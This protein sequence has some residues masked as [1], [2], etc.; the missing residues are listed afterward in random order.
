METKSAVSD[1]STQLADARPKI[2]QPLRIQIPLSINAPSR[3]ECVSKDLQ[4]QQS[5]FSPAAF[6]NT[7][8]FIIPYL[9]QSKTTKLSSLPTLSDSSINMDHDAQIKTAIRDYSTLAFSSKRAGKKDVEAAAYVSLG[10]IYD[11]Q[12]NYMMGINYYKQ[13]LELSEEL[14][15]GTGISIACNCI[16]VNY[17]LLAIPDTDAGT[18]AAGKNAETNSD[19]LRKAIEYHQKHFDVADLGGKFVSSTNLGLCYGILGDIA[20]SGQNHQEALRTAIKMQTLYGQSISVGNLG[21]LALSKGDAK[22]SRTCLEQHLQLSQTLEDVEAEVN[23]WK[24]LAK[25]ATLN[26]DSIA[27]L[28]YLEH[29]RRVAR[30]ENY[31]S[32]LRRIHCQIGITKGTSTMQ[33]YFDNLVSQV[34]KQDEQYL[35]MHE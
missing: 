25:A 35:H 34:M 9:A 7:N 1:Y 27:A 15:D 14:E 11:N 16:G 2:D 10:V 23:A 6:R 28:E 26:E 31:P 5:A 13:Y 12:N 8:Y 21:L 29:A 4:I 33:I 3:V 17:M 32:Q 20:L 19:Y 18:L 22:T 24:L 30:R